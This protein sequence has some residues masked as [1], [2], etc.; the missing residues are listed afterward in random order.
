VAPGN[1]LTVDLEFGVKVNV[2]GIFLHHL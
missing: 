1:Q 2:L